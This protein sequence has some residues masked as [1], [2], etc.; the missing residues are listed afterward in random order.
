[1]SPS[2]KRARASP[3][4]NVVLS[5]AAVYVTSQDESNRNAR[6]HLYLCP[7]AEHP[8]RTARVREALLTTMNLTDTILTSGEELQIHGKPAVTLRYRG[9]T[10]HFPPQSACEDLSAQYYWGT[11]DDA[12]DMDERQRTDTSAKVNLAVTLYDSMY[13][14][15]GF[16]LQQVL[17]EPPPRS[18]DAVAPE[19]S[20]TED[21]SRPY[22]DA[23]VD[24]YDMSSYYQHFAAHHFSVELPPEWNLSE[25]SDVAPM[26]ELVKR[27][28]MRIYELVY[29]MVRPRSVHNWPRS[30]DELKLSALNISS[31]RDRAWFHGEY[32]LTRDTPYQSEDVPF[33]YRH[34]VY[35]ETDFRNGM[36]MYTDDASPT[37][38]AEDSPPTMDEDPTGDPALSQVGASDDESTDEG[39]GYPYGLFPPTTT[40]S[41]DQPAPVRAPMMDVCKC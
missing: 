23:P 10:T 21:A 32:Y 27:S 36:G 2:S 38:D 11:L 1:M 5:V 24:R 34:Q 29:T 20:A 41:N 28:M 33:L 37:R 25:A 8:T 26:T 7:R 40:Y 30:Y 12:S 15:V 35:T 9:V 17:T 31:E 6:L 19:E 3:P 39:E 4:C 14:D 16:T 22:P 18:S 13:D